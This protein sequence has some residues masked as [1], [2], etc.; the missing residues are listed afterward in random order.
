MYEHQPL[1]WTHSD[2][3]AYLAFKQLATEVATIVNGGAR[4]ARVSSCEAF[5]ALRDITSNRHESA[6][7]AENEKAGSRVPRRAYE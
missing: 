4:S 3:P 7:V 1:G 6:W 5:E 2:D